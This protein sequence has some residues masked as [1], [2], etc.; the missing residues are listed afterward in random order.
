[1]QLVF[2]GQ[3]G[4]LLVHGSPHVFVVVVGH[5]GPASVQPSMIVPQPGPLIVVANGAA[6]SAGQDCVVAIMR[7]SRKLAL[8]R[9]VTT[10]P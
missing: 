7:P 3:N 9:S 8:G 5:F 10:G 2:V 4:P 6:N 1:M